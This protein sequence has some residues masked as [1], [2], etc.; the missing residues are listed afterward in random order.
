MF[1]KNESFLKSIYF[2]VCKFLRLLISSTKAL[3]DSYNF[4]FVY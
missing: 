1:L 4:G 3:N 2:K